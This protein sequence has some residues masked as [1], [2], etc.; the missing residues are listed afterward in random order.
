MLQSYFFNHI[1]CEPRQPT[2]LSQTNTYYKHS[3][4]IWIQSYDYKELYVLFHVKH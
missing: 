2:G 1:R 4:S 3:A